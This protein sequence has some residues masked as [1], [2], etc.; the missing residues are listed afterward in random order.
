MALITIATVTVPNW[1]GN[2]SGIVLRIYVNQSFTA[3][4]GTIYMQT[5]NAN[6]SSGLGTF[7]QA[8]DCTVSG[9]ELEIPAITLDSTTDG[10]DNQ[11]SSYSAVLWDSTSGKMIQPFGTYS[12]FTLSATP[13]SITWAQIFTGEETANA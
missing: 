12:K 1:Q 5:V 3:A 8:N 6:A 4:T 2:T 13:T 11:S 9:T 7:F 10:L